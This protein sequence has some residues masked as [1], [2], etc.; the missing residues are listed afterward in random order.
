MRPFLFQIGEDLDGDVDLGRAIGELV[1]F[2]I[3]ADMRMEA[4]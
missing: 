2:G 4:L 3:D 1:L